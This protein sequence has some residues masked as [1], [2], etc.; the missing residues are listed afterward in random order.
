MLL[1]DNFLKLS[2]S[3]VEKG[4]MARLLKILVLF[5]FFFDIIG[6]TTDN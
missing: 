6:I 5:F 1:I 3:M 4:H 2:V